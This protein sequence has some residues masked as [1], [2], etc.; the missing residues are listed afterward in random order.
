[1]AGGDG[2]AG[3]GGHSNVVAR[4]VSTREV[5]NVGEAGGVGGEGCGVV[6]VDG[7]VCERTALARGRRTRGGSEDVAAVVLVA[8]PETAV[9]ASRALV[10]VVAAPAEALAVAALEGVSRVTVDGVGAVAVAVGVESF[11]AS[12]ACPLMAR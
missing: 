11:F 7:S 12:S 9:S 5:P 3:R 4:A 2:S 6:T 8:V 10:C 1:M